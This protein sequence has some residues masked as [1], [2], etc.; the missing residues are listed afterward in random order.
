MEFNKS[1]INA[2]CGESGSGKTSLVEMI[3]GFA[4]PTEGAIKMN[5]IS[6]ENLN[7]F[8][9]RDRVAYCSQETFLFSGSIYEN[10]A[11]VNP[12]ASKE[13]ILEALKFADADKN[14]E[15][16]SNGIDSDI[17]Q[18][19]NVLSGGERQKIGIARAVL[20]RPDV[21]IF[22]ETTSSID[23]T[24]ENKIFQNI[25]SLSKKSIVIFITHNHDVLRF[26]DTIYF[27]NDG[28]L[29]DHGDL[30]TLKHR[31][32]EFKNFLNKVAE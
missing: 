24:S 5:D 20:M 21:Y 16:M 13:D 27:M 22:D 7:I 17:G 29:V 6:L 1:S 30:K 28:K 15:K 18:F 10:L 9:L 12:D 32:T 8:S 31:S 4:T 23:T 25:K 14:I 19:G 3:S 2:I 26:A 11:F